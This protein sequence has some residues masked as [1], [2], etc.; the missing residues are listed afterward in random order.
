MFTGS[1]SVE[2]FRREHALEYQRLVQSGELAKVLVDAPSAPMALGSKILGF[3]LIAAGLILL[4]GVA[5]GFFGS[6]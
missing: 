3:T 6:F 4:T 2:H 5:V 1:L